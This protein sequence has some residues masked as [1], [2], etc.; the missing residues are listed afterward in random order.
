MVVLTEGE[1]S[2]N[3]RKFVRALSLVNRKGI[4]NLLDCL[5]EEEFFTEPASAKYHLNVRGGLCLHKLNVLASARLLFGIST[6]PAI[7]KIPYDSVTIASLCH[8][9]CK[10]RRY[11]QMNDGTY[12]YAKSGVFTLGHGEASLYF[13]SRYIDLTKHEA[14]MI[15]WHMGPYDN[16][17]YMKNQRYIEEYPEVLLFHIADNY[18]SHYLDTLESGSPHKF[19][20][21]GVDI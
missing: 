20:L 10:H 14:M 16:G 3:K 1:I 12:D 9:L 19:F 18:A 8:D 13:T 21:P 4:S 2:N 15:R 6:L 11:I 7:R 17:D 5:E